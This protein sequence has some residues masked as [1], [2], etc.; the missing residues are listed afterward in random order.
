MDESISA[1]TW[2]VIILYR[3][4]IFALVQSITPARIL[5]FLILIGAALFL[6]ALVF[7]QQGIRLNSGLQLRFVSTNDLMNGAQKEKIDL[8]EAQR[9]ADSLDQ[10]AEFPEL[11]QPT[12]GSVPAPGE[13]KEPIRFGQS[14][15]S[16]LWGFFSLLD[17][18]SI[19]GGSTRI[20]HYGDSQIESDRMTS[21]FRDKFQRYFGGRGPGLVPVLSY[22]GNAGV[23]VSTE[24][25]WY[26]YGLFGNMNAKGMRVGPLLSMAALC[27][28]PGDTLNADSLFTASAAM[29]AGSAL[30]STA[31]TFNRIRVFYDNQNPQA[32]ISIEAGGEQFSRTLDPGHTMFTVNLGSWTDMLAFTVQGDASTRI[33]GISMESQTGVIVDNIPLRGSSG[34][35]FTQSNRKMMSDALNGMDVSLIIL[36]FGGNV[37]PYIKDEKACIDYGNWFYSQIKYLQGIRPDAAIIVIGPSDMSTKQGSDYLTYPLLKNVRDA[38]QG[39]AFRAGAGYWDLYAAM[40]GENSMAAWVNADPPLAMP[41]YTHFSP[42]GA[43][44]MAEMF[45]EALMQE[46]HSY[47]GAIR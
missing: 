39:A 43:R 24:G 29:Q 19:T 5:L 8:S 37:M 23:Q 13:V 44:I 41:D 17:S 14:G 11:Q 4:C 27:Q 26:Q 18:L 40:G 38:L 36:Q 20:M 45:Y 42:R 9:L 25:S 21:Y 30:Y 15:K 35:V 22:S 28:L 31:R 33:Q 3:V 16:S 47:Q 1:N 6:V 7:P 12:D 34:T 2:G 46:Y 32:T 10:I